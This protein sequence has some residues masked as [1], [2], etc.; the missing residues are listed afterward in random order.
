MTDLL[1][2]NRTALGARLAASHPLAL[3]VPLRT[4]WNPATCPAHCLPFLAWAFSVDQWHE[5]GRRA[6]S[7][8]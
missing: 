3:P 6:S 2:P 8:A 1:P 5:P 7:A 4:L